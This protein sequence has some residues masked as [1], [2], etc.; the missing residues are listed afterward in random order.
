MSQDMARCCLAD[1]LND[2]YMPGVTCLEHSNREDIDDPRPCRC[3]GSRFTFVAAPWQTLSCPLAQ[4]FWAHL[5]ATRIPAGSTTT[6][7]WRSETRAAPARRSP[8]CR[9]VGPS[10]RRCCPQPRAGASRPW[11]DP[12]AWPRSEPRQRAWAP[13]RRALPAGRRRSASCPR[14]SSTH[15]RPPQAPGPPRPSV[16]CRRACTPY[17]SRTWTGERGS[18]P[19]SSAS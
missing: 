2:R 12:S 17:H 15:P 9:T 6:N 14:D 10:A 1:H 3:F 7:L 18:P 19:N 5:A 11:A 13:L 16:A 8:R 4:S